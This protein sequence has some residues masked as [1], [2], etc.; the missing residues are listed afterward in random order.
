MGSCNTHGSPAAFHCFPVSSCSPVFGSHHLT[1]RRRLAVLHATS[2]VGATGMA[3]SILL[4]FSYQ[5]QVGALYSA[6]GLLSGLF[7]LGLAIGGHLGTRRVSVLQAQWAAMGT[8]VVTVGLWLM[9]RK[10]PIL[11]VYA[12]PLHGLLLL[13]VGTASGLMFPAACIALLSAGHDS[14]AAAAW[15]QAADHAGAAAVALVTVVLLVPVLGLTNTALVLLVLQAV[16]WL[17]MRVH[18]SER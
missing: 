7:M 1:T 2:I 9:A 18:A 17:M 5:T 11:L 12:A 4:F 13:L 14:R 16:A 15:V 6:L 8:T 3:L 10:V